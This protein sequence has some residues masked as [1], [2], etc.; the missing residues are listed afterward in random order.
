MQLL[1]DLKR[2]G[3][4]IESATTKVTCRVF[5]YNSG[6]LE[7]AKFHKHRARTKHLNMKLHHFRDYV[8]RGEVAILPITTLDQVSDYLTIV[9]NNST[10]GWHRLNVQSWSFPVITS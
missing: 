7:M 10:L 4:T 1:K 3:F 8:T 9:V 6:S 5:E 2:S